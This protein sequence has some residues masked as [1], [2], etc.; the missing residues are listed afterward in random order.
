MRNLAVAGA[1]LLSFAVTGRAHEATVRG[2]I[3]DADGKPVAGVEVANF[4]MGKNGSMTAYGGV[5]SDADGKYSV[6][7]PEWMPEP[8][9]LAISADRKSGAVASVQPKDSTDVAPMKLAP[10]VKVSGR[11][12]S[13]E[14]GRK[15]YW[16]NVYI[17]T[18]K[19]A[20]LIQSD[21]SNADF[22]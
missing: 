9:L 21:S 1:I 3:I 12:E 22:A 17:S 15:P 16:T 8:A 2:T 4:W 7:V 19:R 13:K 20:W 18:S 14:L 10:L 11:F 6:K 5:K